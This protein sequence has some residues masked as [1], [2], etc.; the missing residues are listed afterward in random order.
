MKPIRPVTVYDASQVS[1]AF[2]FMQQGVHMGKILIKMPTCPSELPATPSIK[3]FSLSSN[4]AYL[5]A[6]GL[7]GLGRCV[8][9]W[10][11]EQGA[12]HLIFLSRS[13]GRSDEHKAFI[14]ELQAQ[15]CEAIIIAGDV[16]NL[17]DVKKAASCSA[18]P[19]GGVLQLSMVLRVS[20]SHCVQEI[21]QTDHRSRTKGLSI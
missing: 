5:L 8:S 21:D 13:G 15:G 3:E 18:W 2:K 9:N 11:V 17:A 4:K 16:C 7:G 12:R 10:M 6:G 1:E 20:L 14:R 19:I